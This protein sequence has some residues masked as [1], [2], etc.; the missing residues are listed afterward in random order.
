VR[1]FISLDMEGVSGLVNWPGF[2]PPS[3]PDHAFAR[4]QALAEV[5]AVIEGLRDGV[6]E[7]GGTLEDFTVA[8]AH[9]RGLNLDP[10]GLPRDATLIRG[11]PRPHYMVEGLGPEHDL[12]CFIG[13]HSRVGLP[14]ALMDHSYSGA[15]IHEVRL[16]GA[17]VGE[18]E[19]N[20]AYAAHYGVPLGLV[21][22][23]AALESQVAESFGPKVVFVR[24]KAGIGRFAAACEHPENVLERLREGARRAVLSLDELPLYRVAEPCTLEVELAE[25]QMADLLALFP[26]FER[27]GGRSVKVTAPGMPALYRAYLG[28]LLVAGAAKRLKDE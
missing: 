25:T 4:R 20:A 10:A 8:D 11:F 12:A 21:S 24:T 16:N 15:C 22:G 28:L 26:G 2:D 17:P 5:S 14:D 9:A 7:A 13:Y 1:F 19:L 18:T 27:T 6:R 3:S 23:D